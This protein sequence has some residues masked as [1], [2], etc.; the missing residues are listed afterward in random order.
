M[1][2]KIFQANH[3]NRGLN[4]KVASIGGPMIGSLEQT[5]RAVTLAMGLA[6]INVKAVSLMIGPPTLVNKT[7]IF[8]YRTSST[9]CD[10]AYLDTR[11]PTRLPTPITKQSLWTPDRRHQSWSGVSEH[12]IIG[13]NRQNKVYEHQ[14]TGTC[15]KRGVSS[16]RTIG[17]SHKS[18]DFN[19]LTDDL[20]TKWKRRSHYQFFE[21]VLP[22]F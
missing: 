12:W 21:N 7:S 22:N 20:V 16:H 14:T 3:Q 6:L 17:T 19:H 1:T 2:S 8:S 5:I 4:T 9:G 15:H 13:I 10:A 18:S 11:L